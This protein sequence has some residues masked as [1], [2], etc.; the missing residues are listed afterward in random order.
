MKTRF[1]D[2]IIIHCADTRVDQNF[3]SKDIDRW[4][5]ERG[6]SEIGYHYVILLDGTI[7]K[8]RDVNKAGAHCKGYN[9]TSIGVCFMGG[10]N[11]DNSKWEKPTKCQVECFKNLDIELSMKYP[12]IS[13]HGH[14]EYSSKS[15]PNFDICKLYE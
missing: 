9:K 8:G 10:K 3:T 4:H 7:E 12:N 15:C 14:Y 6:W 13:V 1:I 11:A 2:K 5:K